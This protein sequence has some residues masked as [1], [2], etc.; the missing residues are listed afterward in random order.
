VRSSDCEDDAFC[1]MGRCIPTALSPGEPPDARGA[2][3]AASDASSGEPSSSPPESNADRP[4]ETEA[5]P[6]Q[7]PSSSSSS[8]G[9]RGASSS[10]ESCP[11]GRAP[12]TGDLVVNEILVD[13][14]S[15]AKGDVNG[16]GTR[17]AVD[18]EF[19]ELVNISDATLDLHGLS[20]L[21]SGDS[22][23]EVERGCLAADRALVVFGGYEGDGSPDVDDAS[24]RVSSSALGLGNGGGRLT[25]RNRVGAKLDHL[26][27]GDVPAESLTLQPQLRGDTYRPHS[28]LTSGVLVT[29]G[30]CVD[31]STFESGCG[32]AASPDA[33]SGRDV[34]RL[35]AGSRAD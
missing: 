14:P 2:A 12:K 35:D 22:V 19:V 5:T 23:L 7:A 18:D 13:V 8:S 15:G 27:W 32:R 4:A 10:G 26:E 34:G 25:V 16:D 11:E 20:I 31:G 29:P 33:S 6:S 1:R 17:D 28:S 3:L 30:R 9:E 21:E 24:T